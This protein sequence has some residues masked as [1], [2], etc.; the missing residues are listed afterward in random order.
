MSEVVV[1]SAPWCAGC[2]TVKKFLEENSID[3]T[4]V[5]IDTKEGMTIAKDVGIKNIPA[6]F[7]NSV[8]FDGSKIETLNK[9]V[10]VLGGSE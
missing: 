4:E 5:N 8:R 7:V 1:Y 9:I 10:E 2:K 3:Y 6:T